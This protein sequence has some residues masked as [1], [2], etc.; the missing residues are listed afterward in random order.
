MRFLDRILRRRQAVPER[1][2][3]CNVYYDPTGIVIAPTFHDAS[4]GSGAGDPNTVLPLD[5]PPQVIG[6]HVIDAVAA[7]RGGLSV[8]E[9]ARRT[10]QLFSAAAVTGWDALEKRWERIGVYVEPGAADLTIAPMRRYETG[11]YITNEGDPV[12]RRAHAV[13]EIGA[14]LRALIDRPPQRPERR[15]R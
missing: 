7:S 12:Y 14:L 10:D 15:A 11:G 8:E 13:G 3:G 2:R 1:P 6:A 4:G 9:L 5:A